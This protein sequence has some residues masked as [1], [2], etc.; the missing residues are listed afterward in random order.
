MKSTNTNLI[1][2]ILNLFAF[3]QAS[4]LSTIKF[5]RELNDR[6]NRD[7][8]T[9]FLL[10]GHVKEQDRSPYICGSADGP[11]CKLISGQSLSGMH[12]YESVLFRTFQ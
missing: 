1:V 11:Y 6:L 8:D 12:N 3:Y 10:F 5:A 4:A 2:C 9:N 7:I